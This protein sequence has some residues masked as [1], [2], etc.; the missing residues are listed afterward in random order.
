MMPPQKQKR[1]CG[2]K[3]GISAQTK[4]GFENDSFSHHSHLGMLCSILRIVFKQSIIR[5]W[6]TEASTTTRFQKRTVKKKYYGKSEY[7]YTVYSLNIP[8]EFHDLLQPF[9]NKDLDVDARREHA[10][11]II[12]ITPKRQNARENFC[13]TRKT[14]IFIGQ[15][16][17]KN[18]IH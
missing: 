18:R 3:M 13:Y 7:S 11:L 8:K 14:P 10:Q 4:H 2:L 1:L 9:L 6:S 12:T 5:E 16:S 17:L 15:N